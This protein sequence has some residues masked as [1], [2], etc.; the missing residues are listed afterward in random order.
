MKNTLLTHV[1]K[2]GGTTV[3]RYLGYNFDFD[4][5]LRNLQLMLHPDEVYKVDNSSFYYVSGHIQTGALDITRFGHRITILRKPIE[6]LASRLSFFRTFFSASEHDIINSLKSSKEYEIYSEYFSPGFDLKRFFIDLNY[7]LKVK[8]FSYVDPCTVTQAIDTLSKFDSVLDFTKLESEIKR[9]I[10]EN[11]L[12][13]PSKIEQF[14][15]YSYTPDYEE[16]GQLLSPFDELFYELGQ[17][18]FRPMRADI[19]EAYDRFHQAYC[20]THGLQLQCYQT[21]NI[22]TQ[23]MFTVGWSDVERFENGG[24]Q[25]W[26]TILEPTLELPVC[27]PGLYNLTVYFNN[28]TSNNICVGGILRSEIERKTGNL[29]IKTEGVISIID[30]QI[31][32]MNSDWLSLELYSRQVSSA[33]SLSEDLRN[34]GIL[35]TNVL[36]RRIE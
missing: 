10:I 8:E 15:K 32:I 34:L 14:R 21:V 30:A 35:L 4:C 16:A 31:R 24:W 26:S 22:Q 27:F 28:S 17:Q 25:C 23:S 3:D 6:I 12:F 9:L 7:D 19:N 36:L 13:P 1:P 20:C 18:F 2:T 33:S 11:N 5:S 29:T